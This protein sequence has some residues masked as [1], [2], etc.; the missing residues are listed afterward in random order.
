MLKLAALRCGPCQHFKRNLSYVA[1]TRL[2]QKLKE[3]QDF[4]REQMA[5]GQ[6]L[7]Y[8]KGKPLLAKSV[9]GEMLPLWIS[10]PE[11]SFLESD[12]VQN[13]VV[14]GVTSA[15]VA[16]YALNVGKTSPWT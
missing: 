1:Q 11:S 3:D 15:G 10:T 13:S 8:S 16:Q 9:T 7:L 14:L 12:L 4:C 5:A 6:F 2:L